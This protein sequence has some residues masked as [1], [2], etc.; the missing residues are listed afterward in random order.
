MIKN[1]Q[2][3]RFIETFLAN[4]GRFTEENVN[5]DCLTGLHNA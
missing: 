1:S 3:P 2:K 4:F 5:R